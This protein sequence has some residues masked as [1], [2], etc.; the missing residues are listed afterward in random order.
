MC[1]CLW[2]DSGSDSEEWKRWLPLPLLPLWMFVKE[3]PDRK[4]EINSNEEDDGG[5]PNDSIEECIFK[6][7]LTAKTWWL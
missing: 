5:N 2:G 4:K 7:A 3:N 6:D 1:K